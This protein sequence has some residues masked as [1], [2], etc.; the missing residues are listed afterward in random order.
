MA[1]NGD[2]V[3][4]VGVEWRV[5][6]WPPIDEFIK[7]T[8]GEA[9][10]FGACIDGSNDSFVGLIVVSTNIDDVPMI[11]TPEDVARAKH[12]LL[13]LAPYTIGAP[14]FTVVGFIPE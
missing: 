12:R 3:V 2:S 14:V 13:H 5:G 8:N 10:D 6:Q 1:S 11:F 9:Y 7:M 4:A